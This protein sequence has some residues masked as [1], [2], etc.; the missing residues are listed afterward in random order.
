MTT[1]GLFV[2][3]ETYVDPRQSHGHAY[4]K[5]TAADAVL[6][7][8][9]PSQKA[10]G[11]PGWAEAIALLRFAHGRN[12]IFIA[13]LCGVTEWFPNVNNRVSP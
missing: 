10:T 9:F 7:L 6:T 5:L 12:A 2:G 4:H 11:D 8:I 13:I 3:A 1:V